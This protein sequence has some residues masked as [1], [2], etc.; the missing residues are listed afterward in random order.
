V[1]AELRFQFIKAAEIDH[2]VAFLCRLLKVTRQGYYKWLSSLERPYKYAELLAAI[3]DILAEDEENVSYG[4]YRMYLALKLKGYEGSESTVKTV[5]KQNKLGPG[6]NKR[7]P[8]SLTKSDKLAQKEDDLLDRDFYCEMPNCIT[9]TDL[10]EV[11]CSDGKLYVSTVFDCFDSMPLGLAMAD[12]MRADLPCMSLRQAAV[13]F[14]L[15]GAIVHDDRGGQYTGNEFQALVKSLGMRQSM[16][17]AGGRC[18]DNA[19][20]ESNWGR[21]KVE[22]IYPVDSRKLNIDEMKEII[23]RYFMSYWTNRRIST[24][25]DGMPPALKRKLYYERFA[26]ALSA[27]PM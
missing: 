12:N 7:K 23:F 26:I 10:T 5:M 25:N 22:K 20:C 8:H 2:D 11:P 4:H 15:R 6:A 24:A 17:S 21:F 1:K 3:M 27:K 14:D 9:I 13:R 19:R 16:N 18:Y